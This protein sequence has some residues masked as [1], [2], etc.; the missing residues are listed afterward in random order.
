MDGIILNEILL[1]V[2]VSVNP[3]PGT[4]QKGIILLR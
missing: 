4:D 1:Y 3:A 2:M